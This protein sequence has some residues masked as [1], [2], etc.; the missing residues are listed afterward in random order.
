MTN[1]AAGSATRPTRALP[2]TN[3]CSS[4]IVSRQAAVFRPLGSCLPRR[5][6]IATVP[7]E[8]YRST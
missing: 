5:H 6:V 3:S 8:K 4:L 1:G 7:C 2:S